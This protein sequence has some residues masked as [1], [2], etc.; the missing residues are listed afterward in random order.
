MII[1]VVHQNKLT[2]L[3]LN[4]PWSFSL[5]PLE[6]GSSGAGASLG[7]SKKAQSLDLSNAGNRAPKSLRELD[8]PSHDKE[9]SI[10]CRRHI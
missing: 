8:G 2:K 3:L 5:G 4:I 6:A 7:L 9:E 1:I 10:I